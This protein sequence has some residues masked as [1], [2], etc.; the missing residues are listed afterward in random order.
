MSTPPKTSKPRRKKGAAEPP[1]PSPRIARRERRRERSREEIVEAARRVLLK[2]GVAGTTLDAVAQE[3]GL[4]KAALYYYFPSKDALYFEV[5][6]GVFDT[7]TMA[8]QNAVAKA[9]TGPEALR[10][11]IGETVRSFAGQLDDF[12][13]AFLHS[14]VVKPGTVRLTPDQFQR[15]RPLNDRMYGGATKLVAADAERK[16]GRTVIE[17]RLMA[18]LASTAALGLLTMKGLVESFGDPLLYSDE[19]LIDGLARVFEAAAAR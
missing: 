15:L 13:L 9:T 16:R 7:Q 10:A 18:F 6:F 2:N 11:L 3:A 1:A 19:T 14:Q 8:I 17:P 5:M 12:R 4:T